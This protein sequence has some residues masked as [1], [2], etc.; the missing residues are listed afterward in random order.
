[1]SIS[2]CLGHVALLSPNTSAATAGVTA[3]SVA[4]CASLAMRLCIFWLGAID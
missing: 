1:M 3:L 4:R 2:V